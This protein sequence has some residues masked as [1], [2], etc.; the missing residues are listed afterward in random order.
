[1][2]V[3]Q[4]LKEEF[5]HNGYAIC[6]NVID[7]TLVHEA[8]EHVDWLCK[9]HPDLRPENLHHMLVWQD[10]FWVRLLA[11]E[12]ILDCVE[13]II[14]PDIAL[15]ASHYIAKPP[16]DGQAVLWHQDGSYWPL[17]P[18]EVVTAWLSIN[19]STPVNGCMRV[20]PGSHNMEI[21]GTNRRE[22]I[23]NVLKSEMPNEFVES[24]RAVDIVLQPGDISLHHPNIVHGSNPNTSQMWRK[25]L[26]M[27]Y[28][29]TTTCINRPKGEV[30]SILLRCDSVKGINRY[31]PKP[32]YVEGEHMPF[33]DSTSWN[34]ALTTM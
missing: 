21:K 8:D 10:S 12:R 28:V 13:Q 11:D 26:T 24:D 34:Q 4:N 32:L 1:M 15:F 9:R 6:R 29:P 31:S 2:P 14:G 18:M 23:P 22:D 16:S 30:E 3:H 27:R 25:G 17:Q 20:I 7:K 5:E 19:P 33:H